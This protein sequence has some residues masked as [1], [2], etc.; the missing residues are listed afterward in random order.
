V[1]I[2]T[3]LVAALATTTLI[4]VPPA[5]TATSVPGGSVT[6]VTGDR[7]L[8]RPDG[9]VMTVEPAPGREHIPITRYSSGDHEHVV[10]HDA[11]PLLDADR[12]DPRLFDI[13]LLREFGYDDR[14]STLPLIAPDNRPFA[15]ARDGSRWSAL[16]ASG[17]KVW[18]DGKRKALLDESVPRIG[19]PAAW[20]AGYTGAGVT[21]GVVDSGVD[22]THPD[23]A[24]REQAERNFGES[25]DNVDRIGH[26]T[27]VGSTVA[28]VAPDAKLVDAKVFDDDGFATESWIITGMTWAVEQ[29]ADVLNLS[30]GGEDL[31]GVDPVEAAVEALSAE[32]GVLVVAAAGNA[33]RPGTIGSPASADAALAVG[34]VDGSDAMA[35]FS[36]R[37]PRVGDG[38][39]KPEITAPGV[40]ITAAQP[41]GGHVDM[42]GT[43]MASPHVAG[44][45]ALLAQRHPEWTGAQLKA[46]LVASATPSSDATP[47]DQGAGR[48]DVSAAIDQ[49]VT[50]EPAT[51]NAGVVEFPHT[52]PV[53][54]TLTYRNAGPEVTL[55]LAVDNPAFALPE[56]VTV[57]A[58]GQA[59]VTV[60]ADAATEGAHAG[61]IVATGPH[62]S[63]RTPVSVTNEPESYDVTFQLVGR[64]GAPA[65]D[66]VV[67]VLPLDGSGGQVR[68]APGGSLTLRL[69]ARG[70][71]A[72]FSIVENGEDFVL[73]YPALDVTKDQTIV[74]DAR[75]AKPVKVTPPDPA[76]ELLG[77]DVGFERRQ[78]GGQRGYIATL[79]NRPI[80]LAHVGPVLP[81]D[82]MTAWV[83]THFTGADAFYGLAWF[84]R[85]KVPTGFVRTV[86][87]RDV[88]T[89]VVD[90]VDVAGG[91]AER[92]AF[93]SPVG[94]FDPDWGQE[95]TWGVGAPVTRAAYFNAD[96]EWSQYLRQESVDTVS[97]SRR[98][99]AGREYVER[100]QYPVFGPGVR[101]T[102]YP[103]PGAFRDG[104]RLDVRTPLF[105]DSA[106][107]ASRSSIEEGRT[108]LYQGDELIGESPAPGY[109]LFEVPAEAADYR[110]TAS[111]TRPG[112]TLSTEVTVTW[113]F[114]SAHGTARLPLSTVRF[115]PELTDGTAP[116][117]P[118]RVPVTVEGGKA[119]SLTIEVSY[120]E[121]STWQRVK[122]AGGTA[123]LDHPADAASVSLR[124]GVT[125]V[126]GSTATQTIIRA[127]LL[128]VL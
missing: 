44:A 103:T 8:L 78:P 128:D 91:P 17:G 77:L 38:A 1:R 15:A 2:R 84:T 7:V 70:H 98:Y 9:R 114:R 105:A 11:V 106:G 110:L 100:F 54:R 33:Y 29:G 120:D 101:A 108:V 42:D 102:H 113:T 28:A 118:F 109:G 92:M 22:Q 124:A 12:L 127:Y 83:S 55:T 62:T 61:T 88:A 72:E 111:A 6:L 121:G 66:N 56:Y 13:T 104:D 43:S 117:G 65:E 24:G 112:A 39:V 47:F 116:A 75:A 18:L 59:S 87:R 21:V 82:R 45:A 76:A 49:T 122:I 80:S 125:N 95:V 60:T 4:A 36:S 93:P 90:V 74:L 73:A 57:P 31:P 99:R 3:L 85:G 41:G 26:G 23:L 119:R 69:P 51:V 97:P 79:Y 10:P 67:K 48:V 123:R 81:A 89:V 25:P 14:R 58:G 34:A 50:A 53:T 16:A 40:G 94:G 46:A 5:A 71:L 52:E 126:D 86:G 19:A 20:A 115:T 63:V 27:H 35:L 107:N 64:D 32:H 96:A 37:G 68:T 30:L